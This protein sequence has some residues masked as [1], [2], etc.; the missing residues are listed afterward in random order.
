MN[1][2]KKGKYDNEVKSRIKKRCKVQ[3][4]IKREVLNEE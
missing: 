1:E 2:E 3:W 4:R